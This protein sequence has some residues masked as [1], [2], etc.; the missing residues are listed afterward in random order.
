[1]PACTLDRRRRLRSGAAAP[2]TAGPIPQN[3]TLAWNLASLVI[4][5]LEGYAHGGHAPHHHELHAAL[6]S[7]LDDDDFE[8]RVLAGEDRLLSA[9]STDAASLPTLL[10][11]ASPPADET[12]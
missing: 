10:G 4:G 3:A 2:S 9:R 11:E 1:V 5:A 7:A 12:T 6:R 8:R